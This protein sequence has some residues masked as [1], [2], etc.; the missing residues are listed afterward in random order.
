[1]IGTEHQRNWQIS[2]LYK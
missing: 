2:T 1:M